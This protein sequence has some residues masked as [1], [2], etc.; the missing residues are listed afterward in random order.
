MNCPKCNKPAGK[1]GTREGVQQYACFKCPENDHKNFYFRE[2]HTETR[3]PRKPEEPKV[4]TKTMKMGLS[5]TELR[6]KHDIKYQATKAA[7]SL[8][9]GVYLSMSEFVQIAK[10]KQGAR[11]RDIVDHT[12]YEDFRGKA[13]GVVY[14]SHPNSIKKLKDEGVLQ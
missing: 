6:L 7:K 13:G 8:K 4:E 3:Q 5:E 9:E 2:G 1:N 14:W 11:Y 12:D 10:I